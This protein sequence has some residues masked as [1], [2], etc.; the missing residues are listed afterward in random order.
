MKRTRGNRS[1][2]RRR[3]A[4]RLTSLAIDGGRVASGGS[5]GNHRFVRSRRSSSTLA[6]TPAVRRVDNPALDFLAS[7]AEATGE[8]MRGSLAQLSGT[9]AAQCRRASR[10]RKTGKRAG[11]ELAA[12]ARLS[13]KSTVMFFSVRSRRRASLRVPLQRAHARS[14]RRR[15]GWQGLW[16][17]AWSSIWS[18]WASSS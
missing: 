16:P 2:G 17:S 1:L 4:G 18:D 13:K 15:R 6:V 8:S 5:A 10:P 11:A 12:C 14:R 3:I 9:L 7:I